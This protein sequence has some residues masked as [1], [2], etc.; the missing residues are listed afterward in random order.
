MIYFLISTCL[1]SSLFAYDLSFTSAYLDKH[2]TV[3]NAFIPWTRQV[4][5]LSE[6]RYQK[7]P[8]WQTACSVP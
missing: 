4:E 3:K 6:G 2:P 1:T 5:K 7:F 8:E